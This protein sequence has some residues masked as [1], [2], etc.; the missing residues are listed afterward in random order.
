MRGMPTAHAAPRHPR[1]LQPV[2]FL[3][4][5]LELRAVREAMLRHAHRQAAFGIVGPLRR[6]EEPER[7]AD[8]HLL[9]GERE[10]D[11]RL[12]VRRLARS[13]GVLARHADRAL[14]LLEQRRVVDDQHRVRAAD[15]RL[16]LLG[17]HVLQRHRIPARRADEVV[18]LLVVIRRHPRDERLDA[19]ALARPEQPAHVHRPPAL[20]PLV[21]ERCPEGRE[22]AVELALPLNTSGR[23]Y[24][25]PIVRSCSPTPQPT[26]AG[27]GEQAERA[28][29]RG[30]V[31]LEGVGIVG[32]RAG[33]RHAVRGAGSAEV[34]YAACPVSSPLP[35]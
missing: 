29:R 25:R 19:L 6:Q 20:A 26:R 14:P 23:S 7:D 9:T 16:G 32:N 11:E 3:Q 18:H 34:P 33:R 27:W 30:E 24:L 2:H 31:V 1:G 12:A 28:Q 8:R 13:P 17:E 22:P 10:G 35:E 4:R 21:A 15:Q 5:D